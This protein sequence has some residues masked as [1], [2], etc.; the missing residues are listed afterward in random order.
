VVAFGKWTAIKVAEGDEGRL[1][2]MKTRPLLVDGRTKQFTVGPAH[3]VTDRTFVVQHMYRLN[4]SLPQE[5][6]APRWRWER[7]G[8]LLV[9]RVSGKI[10]QLTLPEF[11]SQYSEVSWFRNYAA[12]CGAS[13]DGQTGFVVVI[14]L[15]RRKP[16]MKKAIGEGILQSPLCTAPTWQRNPLRI[17]FST[18]NDHSLMF[19]VKSRAVD[20]ATEDASEGEE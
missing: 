18:P 12:Y 17:T 10:Q 3:D 11:D 7:G 16:L 14:Q 8:W 4:D 19:T 6:G 5:N 9:D 20:V 1:V 13:D 15:G 2:E